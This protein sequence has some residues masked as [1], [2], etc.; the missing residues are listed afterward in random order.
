MGAIEGFWEVHLRSAALGLENFGVVLLE[1]DMLISADAG[2]VY[3]NGIHEP[4][5]D[6][7]ERNQNCNVL[8]FKLTL[9]TPSGVTG[10][11]NITVLDS[12]PM[13]VGF[14]ET[15]ELVLP[16]HI[17]EHIFTRAI[18]L[19]PLDIVVNKIRDWPDFIAQGQK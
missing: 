4:D 11:S 19:G 12:S 1:A 13:Q 16:I 5:H 8:N 7:Y 17:N 10:S 3:W 14:P 6:C 9:S 18:E 15:F 2:D